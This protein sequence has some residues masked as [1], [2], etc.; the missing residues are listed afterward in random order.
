MS[1]LT[2]VAW[3]DGMFI[4]P[5]H[6]QQQ[7]IYF[8][9]LL[10]EYHLTH[11]FHSFGFIASQI[12]RNALSMNKILM[13]ECRGILPDGTVFSAPGKDDL[14]PALSIPPEYSSGT[15]YLGLP[16]NNLVNLVE[17]SKRDVSSKH[18]AFHVEFPDVNCEQTEAKDIQVCKLNLNLFL[19]TDDLNQIS[20]LPILKLRTSIDG[21]YLDQDLIPPALRVRGFASLEAYLNK[22]LGMLTKY[23]NSNAHFF[24]Y[25]HEAKAALKAE[26]M[27]VSQT[28]CKYRYLFYLFSRDPYLTPY[29]LFETIV[30]LISSLSIFTSSSV[31]EEHRI[32]YNHNDLYGSFE[33]L[34]EM[35]EQIIGSLNRKLA[36]KLDFQMG[37]GIHTARIPDKVQMESSDF[38][39]GITFEE[40]VADSQV[41]LKHVKIASASEIRKVISAQ[42]SG[43]KFNQINTLP[44]HVAYEEK[45][46]YLQIAQGGQVWDQ[47][48]SNR[49]LGLYTPLEL[50]GIKQAVLWIISK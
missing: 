12:D 30:K 15:V 37:P 47:I 5:Q 6:F 35:A 14:P 25:E 31:L 9:R 13:V 22:I 40:A 21:I 26:A 2:K 49:D 18:L 46:I 29:K 19:E 24:G 7:D 45:T 39:V 23:A 28:V 4:Y 27:L 8:E 16:M 50:K 41:V 17:Q 11:P 34:M 43:V 48:V 36:F 1:R 38:T 42:V 10:I 33:P 32:D 44:S 3:K 20:C